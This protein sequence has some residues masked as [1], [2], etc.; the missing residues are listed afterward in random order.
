MEADLGTKGDLGEDTSAALEV[1]EVGNGTSE[2]GDEVGVGKVE[3]LDCG[4]VGDEV[5]A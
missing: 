2:T 1:G 3:G 5:L 4:D